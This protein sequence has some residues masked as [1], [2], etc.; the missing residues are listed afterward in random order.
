M[1]SLIIST[2]LQKVSEC[3]KRLAELQLRSTSSDMQ[4]ALELISDA[5]VIS[6]CSEKLLEMK[7]EA[8]FVVCCTSLLLLLCSLS[9]IFSHFPFVF[10]GRLYGILLQVN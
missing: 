6:S 10:F 3:M 5:L 4:S 1:S 9:L 7:A 2:G 8:L